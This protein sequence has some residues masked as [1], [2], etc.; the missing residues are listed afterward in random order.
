MSTK[1]YLQFGDI[2]GLASDPNHNG[3]IEL[4]SCNYSANR[5]VTF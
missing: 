2:K 3:W 1:I 4:V 5:S